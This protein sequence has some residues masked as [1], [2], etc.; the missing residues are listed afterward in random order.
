MKIT[1]LKS[2]KGH[3]SLNTQP[4]IWVKIITSSSDTINFDD[5]ISLYINLQR[6]SKIPISNHI[7]KIDDDIYSL[8]YSNLESSIKTLNVIQNVAEWSK[9][10][11]SLASVKGRVICLFRSRSK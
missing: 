1:I 9:P 2:L 3:S 4:S 8:C 11:S 5:V 10:K 6:E 7:V